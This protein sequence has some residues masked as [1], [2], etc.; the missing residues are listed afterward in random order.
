MPLPFA[1]TAPKPDGQPPAKAA[2]LAVRFGLVAV[3]MMFLGLT[4]V[5]VVSQGSN[6]NWRPVGM[7]PLLWLT[8]AVLVASS[9][10]MERARRAM[11]SRHDA[12]RELRATLAL[13]VVFVVGQL[14]AF[15]Q[16]AAQGVYL[17]TT[18]HGSFFYLMTSLHGLHL[19][20]GLSALAYVTWAVSRGRGG[21]RGTMR[22]LTWV[23]A[24]ALYWHFMGGIWVFLLVVLFV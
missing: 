6:P 14:A 7:P 4:A 24:T 17:S 19:L 21:A 13:G 23:E 18:P 16:L 3:V 2:V 5:Y 1:L 15:G 22:Q 10:T 8:T 20:G 9:V 11:R 12:V